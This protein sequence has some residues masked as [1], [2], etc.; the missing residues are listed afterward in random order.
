[1]KDDL[2]PGKVSGLRRPVVCGTVP[3]PVECPVSTRRVYPA[4]LKRL[5]FVVRC[6][7]SRPF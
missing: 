3:A 5:S 4:S 6:D 7:T 2:A 1:M